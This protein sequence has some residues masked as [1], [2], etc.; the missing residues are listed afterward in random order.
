VT[1]KVGKKI[2]V[3]PT[4]QTVDGEVIRKAAELVSTAVQYGM[5][6]E[7]EIKKRKL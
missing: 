3:L 4:G 1:E 5:E 6:I 2:L 7:R